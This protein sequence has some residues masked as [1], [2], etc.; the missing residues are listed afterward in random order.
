MLPCVKNKQGEE[1]L[2]ELCHM[3]NN[4]KKM[5]SYLAKFFGSLQKIEGFCWY[6]QVSYYCKIGCPYRTSQDALSSGR[7]RVNDKVLVREIASLHD[8]YVEYVRD[9]FQYPP[10]HEAFK[11]AFVICC[12][13]IL[14]GSLIAER[15]ATFCDNK[16]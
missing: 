6:L 2:H 15:L 12:K 5:V 10:F 3:W 8:K 9:Y 4:H 11:K 16:A 1:M 7:R 14:G 13:A